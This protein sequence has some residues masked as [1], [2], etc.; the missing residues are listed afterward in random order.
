MRCA[1]AQVY[2]PCCS[3]LSPSTYNHHCSAPAASRSVLGPACRSYTAMRLVRGLIIVGAAISL[4][5]AATVAILQEVTTNVVVPA[6]EGNSTVTWTRDGAC[7]PAYTTSDA[8]TTALSTTVVLPNTSMLRPPLRVPPRLISSAMLTTAVNPNPPNTTTSRPAE[9][10][11]AGFPQQMQSSMVGLL[12][13]C[14]MS[15]VMF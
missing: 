15:L 7:E 3:L 1:A 5:Q 14:I 8:G 2:P 6:W 9:A 13:F 11:G 12:G 4:V 10:T